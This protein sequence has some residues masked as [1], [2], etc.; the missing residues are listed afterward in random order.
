MDVPLQAEVSDAGI[1]H[2]IQHMPRQALEA[3]AGR[4]EK[5]W[6]VCSL[7]LSRDLPALVTRCEQL[8]DP[9]SNR[10]AVEARR[11]LERV[12]IE[13]ASQARDGKTTSGRQKQSRVPL[14]KRPKANGKA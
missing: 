7:I 14:E 4:L 8:R 3:Y 1:E 2:D 5:A 12:R 6:E 9:S 13:I 10:V 11:M